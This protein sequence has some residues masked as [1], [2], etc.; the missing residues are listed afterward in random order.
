MATRTLHFASPRILSLLYASR[1]QNLERI[2]AVLKV[3]LTSRDN[4]LEVEGTE[5]AIV[6][7]EKLF[8]FLNKAREQGMNLADAD[9]EHI[10]MQVAAGHIETLEELFT[11]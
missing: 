9:V 8:E 10:L 2:E 7:T 11:D 3:K 1:P 6:Q 4:W 5:E